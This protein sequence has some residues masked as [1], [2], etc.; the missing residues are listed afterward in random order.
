MNFNSK[1]DFFGKSWCFKSLLFVLDA[2]FF[3]NIVFFFILEL[4]FVVD[5]FFYSL[6]NWHDAT[7]NYLALSCIVLCTDE[8]VIHRPSRSTLRCQI[9]IFSFLYFSIYKNIG[10]HTPYIGYQKVAGGMR[11]DTFIS[12]SFLDQILSAKFLSKISKLF[13]GENWHQSV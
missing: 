13:G 6:S 8:C 10:T 7:W 4:S 12:L 5:W 3:S 2:G 11:D 9:N 1:K